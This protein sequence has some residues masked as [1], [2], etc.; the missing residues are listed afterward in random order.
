MKPMLAAKADLSKV[1]F[2]VL[3]SPKLDGIRCLIV[4]GKA[5]TR[6]LKP[7]PNDFIRTWLEANCPEGMDGELMLQ[8]PTRPFREV[9]SA[10]MRKSGC[11]DFVFKVF[12]LIR[13]D[14]GFA[15]R[16]GLLCSAVAT[17]GSE[18]VAVV[19]HEQADSERE[20][21]GF[22]SSFL[23]EG[24]EGLMVRS[25]D[26]PYKYGRSGVREGYLLKVKLFVDEEAE[27][28][29]FTEKMHNANEPK[30]DNLG[31]TERSSHR[32]NMIPLGT[33]GALVCRFP[34]GTTF[35]VGTGF[36]DHTRGL[37]WATKESLIGQLAKVKYQPDPGGRQPGQ[38]P[39]FPV[40]L[41]MRDRRDT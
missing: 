29:G 7:I 9:T 6:S 18:K 37:L 14:L 17:I 13:E 19:P 15:R 8:D 22:L 35:N 34:D 30:K 23:E 5:V 2:P 27:V 12:D 25:L 38:A 16:F 21:R 32:E 39:R 20:L 40:W 36:D 28:I 11:P 26:G 33:L 41:G 24:F 10:V 4:N 3:V 1:A 31:R